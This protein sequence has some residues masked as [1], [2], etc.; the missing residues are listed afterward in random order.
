VIR[1]AL[2]PL[3]VFVF[4]ACLQ[5]ASAQDKSVTLAITSPQ[6][7]Q[8]LTGTVKV[9][10]KAE[11]PEGKASP[12]LAYVGLGG[13]TWQK[14]EPSGAQQWCAGPPNFAQYRV[15]RIIMRILNLQRPP[16][17]LQEAFW[18]TPCPPET[19]ES[20]CPNPGRSMSARPFCT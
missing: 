1:S 18:R 7:I 15:R 5:S 17:K 13:G 6:A 9:T 12:S 20:P 19:P 16:T 14:M 8:E 2:S 3:T 10:V 4:I 11:V